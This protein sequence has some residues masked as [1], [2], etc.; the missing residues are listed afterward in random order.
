MIGRRLLDDVRQ[1]P[2]ALADELMRALECHARG[3]R[4]DFTPEHA[5]YLL[6]LFREQFAGKHP[7]AL[8]SRRGPGNHKHQGREEHVLKV[9]AVAYVRS[10]E[11]RA[12]ARKE[13][14]A[15]FGIDDRTLRYWRRSE[16]LKQKASE[17]VQKRT[18]TRLA[19]L[20]RKDGERYRHLRAEKKP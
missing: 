6:T 16:D 7:A 5:W 2:I 18:G 17:I 11:D 10:A 9:S 4:D 8:Q 14:C 13:V 15:W 20:A 12:A 1:N 3:D 19:L